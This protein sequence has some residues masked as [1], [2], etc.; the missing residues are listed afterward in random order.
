MVLNVAAKAVIARGDG[1]VLILRESGD[2]DTNTRVGRYQLPGGRIDIGESLFE[3][4]K[5][6]VSEETGLTIKIGRPLL[7]GEWRP[8]VKGV[9]HQIIGMFFTCTTKGSGVRLSDEHDKAVW[10]DPKERKQ[11]DIV[12]PDYQAV[13]EFAD[14]KH[15]R[16]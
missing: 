7:A 6:E 3:G 5:R 13:E 15:Q 4:L 2:H 9:P 10:I 16:D 1:K 14:H 11:Y 8:V 12:E